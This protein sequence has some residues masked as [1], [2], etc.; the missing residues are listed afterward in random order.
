MG[1]VCGPALREQKL[2]IRSEPVADVGSHDDSIDIHI[3]KV[4]KG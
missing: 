3:P 4:S 1:G 2:M